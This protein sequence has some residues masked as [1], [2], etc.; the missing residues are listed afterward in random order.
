MITPAVIGQ[1]LVSVVPMAEPTG[2]LYYTNPFP[3]SLIDD[4]SSDLISLSGSIGTDLRFMDVCN[5][6]LYSNDK[7]A[8]A[9]AYEKLFTIFKYRLVHPDSVVSKSCL[10]EVICKTLNDAIDE[11]AYSQHGQM[12]APFTKLLS[13][14][15]EATMVQNHQR[16][17]ASTF[18]SMGMNSRERK[19]SYIDLRKYILNYISTS[20]VDIKDEQ[21]KFFLKKNLIDF[22]K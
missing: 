14:I 9:K 5:T 17:F 1:D 15:R 21:I 6:I 19:Y 20:D 2:Q 16:I 8:V 10:E 11:S 7:E 22:K 18:A 4:V 13:I 3:D 12:Y